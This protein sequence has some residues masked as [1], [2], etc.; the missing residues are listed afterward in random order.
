[1]TAEAVLSYRRLTKFILSPR[2]PTILPSE[3]TP[4]EMLDEVKASDHG[5]KIA[6][7]N[8]ANESCQDN[9]NLCMML[10]H[11]AMTADVKIFF[12]N[13]KTPWELWDALV[14]HY[15][16]KSLSDQQLAKDAIKHEIWNPP[17]STFVQKMKQLQIACEQAN[18]PVSDH[19]L[20]TEILIKLPKSYTTIR[21]IFMMQSSKMEIAD[22]TSKLLTAKKGLEI[23]SIKGKD[24]HWTETRKETISETTSLEQKIA[25]AVMSAMMATQQLHH[26]NSSGT[27]SD[28][29]ARKRKRERKLCKHC[30]QMS[31]HSEERCFQNPQGN[32]FRSE[33]ETQ[34]KMKR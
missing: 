31:F 14:K 29:T 15:E 13:L 34:K 28:A 17:M 5:K 24:A 32:Q 4:E 19:D 9:I 20:C 27:S 22:I 18:V 12:K 8:S 3:L 26:A 6:A 1:M 21:S 33:H 10:L 16:S 7:I 2:S 23:E 25:S 30:N 11:N